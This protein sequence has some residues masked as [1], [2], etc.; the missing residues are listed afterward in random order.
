MSFVKQSTSTFVINNNTITDGCFITLNVGD[1]YINSSN[2]NYSPNLTT[3]QP[4]WSYTNHQVVSA[5]T[6]IQDISAVFVPGDHMDSAPAQIGYYNGTNYIGSDVIASAQYSTVGREY[7]NFNGATP[8]DHDTRLDPPQ[9]DTFS[10]LNN[11]SSNNSVMLCVEIHGTFMALRGLNGLYMHLLPSE[12]VANTTYS[13]YIETNSDYVL[14]FSNL[15]S[16]LHSAHWAFYS[17][18]NT[19]NVIL[20]NRATTTCLTL[21]NSVLDTASSVWQ[22][23]GS[24]PYNWVYRIALTW[25]NNDTTQEC[26]FKDTYQQSIYRVL[27]G[28]TLATAMQSSQ[29]I[30]NLQLVTQKTCD[31]KNPNSLCLLAYNSDA[32]TAFQALCSV[33][34]M[35]STAN[36]QAWALGNGIDDAQAIV[37][38]YAAKYPSDITFAGCVNLWP[39]RELQDLLSY[40]SPPV[41]LNPNCNTV[42]C[43]PTISY[44]SRSLIDN[45]CVQQICN[46]ALI[47]LGS[48]ISSDIN[49]STICG[50]AVSENGATATVNVLSELLAEIQTYF[51]G[52]YTDVVAKL[53]LMSIL[54]TVLIFI[55]SFV[56]FWK[57]FKHKIAFVLPLSTIAAATAFQLIFNR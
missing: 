55:V 48:V 38:T 40:N 52:V 23:T 41:S 47:V 56:V 50:S 39:T 27:G 33:G 6:A 26:V 53:S 1:I 45:K 29:S 32:A 57:I 19:N 21:S 44:R 13:G 22:W 8:P 30:F 20:Q 24:G 43:K 11:V 46:Q 3:Q 37:S 51:E 4:V 10:T 54:T 7:R 12:K 49:F 31:L 18:A 34:D 16:C 42:N 35:M 5:A 36:C 14:T 2:Y 9:T 28:N 25:Y 15:P 17:Q